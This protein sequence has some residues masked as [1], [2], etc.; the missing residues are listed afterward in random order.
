MANEPQDVKA[1]YRHFGMEPN[2]TF[3]NPNG[4]LFF[5]FF[6]MMVYSLFH[7]RT[8][9]PLGGEFLYRT[10]CSLSVDVVQIQSPVF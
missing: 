2:S 6:V 3:C 1:D 4:F 7:Q 8:A 9:C 5:L 10:F